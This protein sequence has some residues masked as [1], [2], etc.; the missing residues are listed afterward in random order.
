MF[1]GC[2]LLQ[3]RVKL[4]NQVLI[5]YIMDNLGGVI[6]SEYEDVFGAGRIEIK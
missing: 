1:D 5:D 4:D 6:G 2:T 3:D